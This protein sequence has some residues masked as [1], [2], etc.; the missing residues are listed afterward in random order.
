MAKLTPKQVEYFR[1][2]ELLFDS[3]GW[4][5]LT[6]GWKQEQ[7]ALPDRVFFNAKDMTLVTEARIRYE[8][9]TELLALPAQIASQKE[10]ALDAGAEPKEVTDGE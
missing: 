9:L 2:M 4:S 3:S 10:Q 1:S 5:V 7:E 6:Q 8:L